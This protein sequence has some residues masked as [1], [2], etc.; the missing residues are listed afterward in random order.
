MIDEKYQKEINLKQ[1]FNGDL[2]EFRKMAYKA[3]NLMPKR[4]CL[5][6]TNLCN[7]ACDF[8]YQIRTKQKNSL[9]SE[10]WVNFIKQL[11]DNSRVT[12]TG[13]EPLVFKNFKDVFTEATKKIK[14]VCGQ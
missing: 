7:L 4:Y 2:A 12:L 8:C 13:G 11:P 6:L 5:V 14:K 3:D 10:D 9:T 1:K